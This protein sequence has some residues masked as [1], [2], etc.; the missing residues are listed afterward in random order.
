MARLIST[1]A[2]C[3][4]GLVA[5]SL[6]LL[7][8]TSSSDEHRVALVHPSNAQGIVVREPHDARPSYVVAAAGDIACQTKPWRD[9]DICQYDKTADLIDDAS[10]VQ[11]L[12]LGDDQYETGTYRS[13]RAYYGPTW[14]RALQNTSPVPGNHEYAD[15]PNAKPTGY[16]RYFGDRVKG[17]DG[18][19][20]YS[21]DLP[22]GC[23]PGR[24]VCWHFIALNSELCFSSGGCGPASDPSQPG[25]GNRMYEWLDRDLAAHPES[26][27]PCALAYWH[28]PLFTISSPGGPEPAVRPLWNL[29]YR[30]RADVV[31]NGHSHNY[32]RWRQQDPAGAL[33]RGRGIREFVVGTGGANKFGLLG[34]KPANL[35]TAQDAAFGVLRITLRRAGYSW[36]WVRASGQIS[37]FTDTRSASVACV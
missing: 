34:P 31:L 1:T 30:S 29:L 37:G 33:D 32:Q 11:V 24:G 4:T 20:Y 8:G 23:V 7:E 36:R 3:L 16:F 28:H 6:V 9:P 18:L 12:A 15:D 21:F 26:E 35:A 2:R 5:L 13:Y 10:L 19:G 14:G 25:D 17:P 27:Y 22:K